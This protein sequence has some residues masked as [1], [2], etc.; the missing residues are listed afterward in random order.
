MGNGRCGAGR[1]GY[2]SEVFELYSAVCNEYCVI[3]QKQPN[4]KEKQETRND[5]GFTLFKDQHSSQPHIKAGWGWRLRNTEGA[6]FNPTKGKTP[7]GCA[8]APKLG[9]L[10]EN[11]S[12]TASSTPSSVR[13]MQRPTPGVVWKKLIQWDNKSKV[14]ARYRSLT[15]GT[16]IACPLHRMGLFF[17]VFWSIWDARYACSLKPSP[18]LE[19]RVAWKPDVNHFHP[20]F[21]WQ[22]QFSIMKQSMN[23]I[24]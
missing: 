11:P 17:S 3:G 18:C 12:S 14:S 20:L 7:V 24:L 13:W 21:N 2:F 9:D 5:W 1:C 19:E 22:R 4:L 15:D 10:G 23:I 6:H 16:V 8:Q